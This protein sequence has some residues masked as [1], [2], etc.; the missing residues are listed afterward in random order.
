MS[1]HRHFLCVWGRWKF[2]NWRLYR[3]VQRHSK[4]NAANRW[5]TWDLVL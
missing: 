2:E 3:Q 5:M 4:G 1:S